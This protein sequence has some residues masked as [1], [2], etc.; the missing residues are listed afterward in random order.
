LRIRID[1]YQPM[2]LVSLCF[3]HTLVLDSCIIDRQDADAWLATAF[4]IWSR[5]TAEV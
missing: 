2:H 1:H 3:F 5:E 4:D